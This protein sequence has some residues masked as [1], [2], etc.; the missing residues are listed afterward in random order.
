M[1]K[2]F[3]ICSM[4]LLLVIESMAQAK[5]I[6]TQNKGEQALVD[7]LVAKNALFV[8]DDETGVPYKK[9]EFVAVLN[10]NLGISEAQAGKIVKR[11]LENIFAKAY[12]PNPRP[13]N[14]PCTPITVDVSSCGCDGGIVKIY[15]NIPCQDNNPPQDVSSSE[16]KSKVTTDDSLKIMIAKIEPNRIIDLGANETGQFS[17]LGKINYKNILGRISKTPRNAVTIAILDTGMPDLTTDNQK[18]FWRNKNEVLNNLTDNDNNQLADDIL[19]YNFIDMNNDIT[20]RYDHGKLMFKTIL[21][22]LN[23][24]SPNTNLS[25]KI[26]IMSVKTHTDDGTGTLFSITCGI[27]YAKN[28]GADII[29][30]SF[31]YTSTLDVQEHDILK[32]TLLGLSEENSGRKIMFVTSSG[33]DSLRDDNFN[34]Y[35][36]SF[37]NG[38]IPNMLTVAGALPNSNQLPN[39]SHQVT[40][41]IG[42]PYSRANFSSGYVDLAADAQLSN[43]SGTSISAAMVSA[44]LAHIKA[45]SSVASIQDWKNKLFDLHCLGLATFNDLLKQNGYQKNVLKYSFHTINPPI[46]H[47]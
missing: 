40:L 15:I 5:K 23:K 17:K 34:A 39:G 38:D 32:N 8:I 26:R 42:V 7:R 11:R 24:V 35:L 43:R 3:L 13:T 27:Q 14:P 20:D 36:A 12:Q 47:K 28:M 18:Y 2:K 45:T 16:V 30:A 22:T 9:N 31:N 29:N 10:R 46:Q 33:N 1:K 44:T 41:P 21:S 19:G 6:S 4:L 37:N 25:D